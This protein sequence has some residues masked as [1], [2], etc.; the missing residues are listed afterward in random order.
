M[1]AKR[2]ADWIDTLV[3]LVA[4]AALAALIGGLMWTGLNGNN[5][6][7]TRSTIRAASAQIADAYH[8][9]RHSEVVALYETPV[10]RAWFDDIDLQA[11]TGRISTL[12]KVHIA[13]SYAEMGDEETAFRM[14]LSSAG[15]NEGRYLAQ[16]RL[17]L[18]NCQDLSDV[19]RLA[20]AE[21]WTPPR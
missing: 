16:C 6:P 18:H 2:E 9:G 1:N 20:Q 7:I 5:G 3:A 21:V 11:S 8:A 15:L 17:M 12:T 10:H 19:R 13:D 4:L 14:Y